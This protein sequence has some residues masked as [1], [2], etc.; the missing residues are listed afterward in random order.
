M[1]IETRL[2]KLLSKNGFQI[3]LDNLDYPLDFDSLRYMELLILIEEEFGFDLHESDFV[4]LYTFKD[5]FEFVIT[6][7]EK[8]R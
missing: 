7:Y 5:L 6:E 1:N 3:T 4:E 8:N 2:L